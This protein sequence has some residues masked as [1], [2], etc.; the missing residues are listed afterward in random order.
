MLLT[1]AQRHT[2]TVNGVFLLPSQLPNSNKAVRFL[3]DLKGKFE[4]LRIFQAEDVLLCITSHAVAQYKPSTF[5][6]AS[7]IQC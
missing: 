4:M 6:F 1:F 5:P 7:P 2:I 3:K